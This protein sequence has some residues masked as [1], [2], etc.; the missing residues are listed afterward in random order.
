MNDYHM[1]DDYE[2]FYHKI[3]NSH[4]F[5]QYCEAVYGIDFSQDGFADLEQIT[6][7]LAA[8]NLSSKAKMLEIGCGNGKFCAYIREQTGTE[9]YGFDYS[10]S[11]I[12]SAKKRLEGQA[13]HFEVAIIDH[14]DYPDDLFDAIVSVDTLYFTDNLYA[15]IKRIKRWLKP[16]GIFAAYYMDDNREPDETQLAEALRK[17]ELSYEVVDYSEHHYRLMRRKHD[18]VLAMRS[19]LEN[20]GL[21]E[22][23]QRMLRESFDETVTL[24]S[25]RNKHC[26]RRYLYVV[27]KKTKTE[28]SENE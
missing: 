24:D 11:A 1:Y 14:K 9:V 5:T 8:L 27:H 26:G 12:T 17:N 28:E 16:K 23:I 20:D 18:T 21:A 6:H 10:P 4:A 3:E 22:H 15:L 2:N 25:F 13:K 7:L 19:V